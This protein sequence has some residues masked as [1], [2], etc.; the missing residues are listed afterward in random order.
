MED[1]NCVNDDGDDIQQLNQSINQSINAPVSVHQ[2]TH[3]IKTHRT[4]TINNN[5]KNNSQNRW[6]KVPRQALRLARGAPPRAPRPTAHVA[7][8]R[9][10]A[11]RRPRLRLGGAMRISI[12]RISVKK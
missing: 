5:N 4:K 6:T 7:V 8:Q 9:C 11:R 1:A 12:I 10:R 3:R 2:E